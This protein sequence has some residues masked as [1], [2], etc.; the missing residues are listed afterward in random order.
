MSATFYGGICKEGKH[1][2]LVIDGKDWY[3][4]KNKFIN[5]RF[6]NVPIGTNFTID[7]NLDD[8]TLTVHWDTLDFDGTSQDREDIKFYITN[9][10]TQ[11]KNRVLAS[12]KKKLDADNIQNMTI[13][14]L[15]EASWNMNKSQKAALVALII[16]EVGY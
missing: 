3:W 5:T 13:R 7:S 15:K 11:K 14:D 12:V 9:D 2:V 4:K 6:G 10:A 1:H 16:S 8:K